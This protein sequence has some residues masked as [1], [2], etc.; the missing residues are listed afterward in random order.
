MGNSSGRTVR[1]ALAVGLGGRGLRGGWCGHLGQHLGGGRKVEVRALGLGVGSWRKPP[2]ALGGA[3]EMCRTPTSSL[4]P[5]EPGQQPLRALPSLCPSPAPSC[6]SAAA[7][8]PGAHQLDPR[9]L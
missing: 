8:K 1:P 4:P 6:S 5:R 3:E 9:R 7:P 2:E